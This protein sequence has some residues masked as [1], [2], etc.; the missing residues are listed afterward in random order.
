[1]VTGCMVGQ[2][3][4]LSKGSKSGLGKG[5]GTDI[6]WRWFL[7]FT[8][9][10]IAGSNQGLRDVDCL[11]GGMKSSTTVLDKRVKGADSLEPRRRMSSMD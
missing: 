5:A 8:G 3:L 10:S 11:A 7:P 9:N 6:D 1:M 2:L 4:G